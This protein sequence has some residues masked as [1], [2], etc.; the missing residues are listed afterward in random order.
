MTVMNSKEVDIEAKVQSDK[1]LKIVSDIE[2]E[3]LFL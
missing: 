3:V 1:E 2:Y